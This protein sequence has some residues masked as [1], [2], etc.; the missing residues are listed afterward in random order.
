MDFHRVRVGGFREA[1]EVCGE[2]AV[3]R[4]P[5]FDTVDVEGEENVEGAFGFVAFAQGFRLVRQFFSGDGPGES[6][7]EEGLGVAVFI[8]LEAVD[9]LSFA[10]FGEVLGCVDAVVEAQED[11]GGLFEEGRKEMRGGVAE[12]FR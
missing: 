11:A 1:L 8:D 10:R 9:A 7:F 5:A 2:P 12:H 3:G 6:E 4:H